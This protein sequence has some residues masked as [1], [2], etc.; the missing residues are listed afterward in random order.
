MSSSDRESRQRA[1]RNAI[2]ITEMEGPGH[3]PSPRAREL[4]Q[5]YVDGHITG[6]E[7]RDAILEHA[8]RPQPKKESE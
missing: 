6:Q 8:R 3:G 1:V 7:M 4:L 2:A 5:A